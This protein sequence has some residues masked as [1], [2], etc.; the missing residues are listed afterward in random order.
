MKIIRKQIEG[1]VTPYLEPD[2]TLLC[3]N[4]EQGFANSKEKDEE[5]SLDSDDLENIEGGDWD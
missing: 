1:G 3:I 2:C 5:S 4:I